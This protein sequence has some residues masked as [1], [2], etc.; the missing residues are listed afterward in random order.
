[1]NSRNN[2]KLKVLTALFGVASLIFAMLAIQSFA[3]LRYGNSRDVDLK[4]GSIDVR[5][6]ENGNIT[7][8]ASKEKEGWLLS[9][10][11]DKSVDP[12]YAYD[13]VIEA[14]NTA[15]QPEY[16][17]VIVRKYWMDKDNKRVDLDPSLIKLGYKNADF[18]SDA[19]IINDAETTDE[20]T[21]YYMRKAL[22]AKTDSPAL[23]DKISADASLADAYT[24][25]TS[26]DGK[27]I[28]ATYEYD[29]L[30]MGLDIE[31]QSIQHTSANEAITS[32]WGVTNVTVSDGTVS[33]KR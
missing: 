19:W 26:E 15:D 2:K 6:L 4:M 5:L 3:A 31:V 20:Q 18:N 14:R 32:A 22:P 1:M 11:S 23:F 29:G 16:V 27:T 10:L 33:I 28:T 17:R 8:E 12:G 25:E 9:D 13:E 30:H 7:P 21:V 24:L